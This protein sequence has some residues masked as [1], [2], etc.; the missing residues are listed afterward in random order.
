MA[1]PALAR[2]DAAQ[3]IRTVAAAVLNKDGILTDIKSYGDHPL[4]YTIRRPGQRYDEAFMWQVDFAAAPSVLE[5][6]KHLLKVD[7]R[8]IRYVVLKR[9]PFKPLPT[10]PSRLHDPSTLREVPVLMLVEISRFF[11]DACGADQ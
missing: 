7:D 11:P 3:V 5:D 1:R 9:E 6:L 8:I 10:T 4:A 2:P